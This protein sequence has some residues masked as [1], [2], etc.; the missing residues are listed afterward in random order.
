MISNRMDQSNSRPPRRS[1]RSLRRVDLPRSLELRAAGFQTSEKRS[2]SPSL[3]ALGSSGRLRGPGRPELRRIFPAMLALRPGTDVIMRNIISQGQ[4]HL[5][6]DTLSYGSR[7][8]REARLA[9]GP[10]TASTRRRSERVPALRVVG[11][12]WKPSAQLDSSRQ[13]TVL[14][15]DRAD[16][17]NIGLGDNEHPNSMAARIA[18]DNAR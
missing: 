13:L 17:G 2:F 16:R 12:S 15:E 3:L 14:V 1:R 10:A 6:P 4:G 18:A 9:A 8:S 5:R 11:D 7:R